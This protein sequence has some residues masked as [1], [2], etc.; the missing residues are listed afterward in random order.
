VLNG[1]P[2]SGSIRLVVSADPQHTDIYDSTYFN[3]ALEFTKTIALSPATVNSTTGYVDTPQQSQ[4]FLSLT[5]DEFRIFK[6]TPVNVG[7]ELRL[8][9]TGET[10]AL[11]ASD[12][13]TVSGLAQVKV[14]IK[15]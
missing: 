1:T 6:N 3:A 14:V 9:D 4:V 15:D 10:V 12:F 2:L 8:D 5:Q 7:F 11:R 13:V